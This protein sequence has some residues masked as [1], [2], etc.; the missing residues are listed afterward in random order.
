MGFPDP[1]IGQ[2][3]GD[4]RILSLLG[5]GGM[6][7]VYRGYDDKLERFS[8]VKVIDAGLIAGE[9]EDEYRQRFLREARAIARL[10]HRNIVGVYQFGEVDQLVYMAMAFIE[11]RDLGHIVRD[12][13]PP[14]T[15]PQIVRIMHDM[16]GALDYAH[17]GGVIHRDVKPSNIMVTPEGAA[18]L[19]DFGLA[20]SVPEGSIGATFGSA[21]YIAPEQ[22]LSSANAVP[23]SDLYSLGVVLYQLLAG[24]VPFDDPSAMSVALKHLSEAPPP[25]RVYNS[26]ISEGVQRVVLKMLEKEPRDRYS[27]GEEMVRALEAALDLPAESA[28][29]GDKGNEKASVLP[30]LSEGGTPLGSPKTIMFPEPGREFTPERPTQ[31]TQPPAIKR[32]SDTG[33]V[34]MPVNPPANPP[35]SLPGAAPSGTS[36]GASS[37]TGSNSGSQQ[38]KPF[39][40]TD[41]LPAVQPDWSPLSPPKTST[42]SQP[43]VPG[44][45]PAMPAARSSRMGLII[46]GVVAAMLFI[47]LAVIVANNASQALN[48]TALGADGTPTLDDG[49]TNSANADGG[50]RVAALGETTA[51]AVAEA[52]AEGTS[53]ITAEGTTAEATAEVTS[54]ATELLTRRPRV[55]PTPAGN[56]AAVVTADATVEADDGTPE[57]ATDDVT[58]QASAQ[59]SDATPESFITPTR[60]PRVTGTRTRTP[61][62]TPEQT[63]ELT[64][65]QRPE[66]TA[67]LPT[68]EG[69]PGEAGGVVLRYDG[70]SLL[71][72]NRSGR[73]V[74][75]ESLRFVRTGQSGTPSYEGAQWDTRLLS[76]P[77][78]TCLQIWRFDRVSFLEQPPECTTRFWR[79]VGQLRW[80]W[81]STDTDITFDVLVRGEVRATCP[82][83]AAP[84]AG[85]ITPTLE[86]TIPLD[87]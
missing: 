13:G 15:L 52:N 39:L 58:A 10:N 62:Q 37:G 36:S 64:S 69:S 72:V 67:A 17:A 82:V 42:G 66:S 59:G 4:Y 85:A 48:A 79:G 53:E 11:G 76:V 2:Q 23:Q 73:S 78:R 57:L 41:E 12:G 61:E 35:S 54:V 74:N 81:F 56:D 46:G 28:K 5:R 14:L 33:R 20:L 44:S 18:V 16:A 83:A 87:E 9:N 47:L 29:N 26:S 7:R 25:P 32:M 30:P 21:H 27:S 8:A 43:S 19:T 55:S 60:T 38:V 3:L 51:E 34:P 63:L 49:T 75:L 40:T 45:L 84:V 77:P 31:D 80:F 70:E 71:L 86:C 50:T 68:E 24:R 65:E 22:A 1:L 6:A